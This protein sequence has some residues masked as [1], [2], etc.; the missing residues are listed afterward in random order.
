MKIPDITQ[1]EF[2]ALWN[3]AKSWQSDPERASNGTAQDLEKQ[4]R[5]FGRLGELGLAKVEYRDGQVYGAVST[6]SGEKVLD[7]ERYA[8]WKYALD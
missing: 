6:E 3:I 8:Q 1:E 5:I 2:V 4:R 7:D